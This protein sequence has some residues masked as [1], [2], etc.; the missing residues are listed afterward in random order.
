MGLLIVYAIMGIGCLVTGT[1]DAMIIIATMMLV[2]AI[3]D[4]EE[5]ID[6]YNL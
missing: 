5:L 2:R 4:C 1:H 3:G 6:Y